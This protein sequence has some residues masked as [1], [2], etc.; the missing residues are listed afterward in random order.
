MYSSPKSRCQETA[1]YFLLGWYGHDHR[2]SKGV[3]FQADPKYRPPGSEHVKLQKVLAFVD[4]E[5]YSWKIGIVDKNL[6][7]GHECWQSMLK[8]KPLT[9]DELNILRKIE[10]R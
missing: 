1:K 4:P 9:V 7:S 8:Q 10:S 3:F 5:E 2:S 6:T